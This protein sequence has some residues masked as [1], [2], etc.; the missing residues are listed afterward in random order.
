LKFKGFFKDRWL[1]NKLF[2][3]FNMSSFVKKND[4]QWPPFYTRKDYQL[5]AEL[6]YQMKLKSMKLYHGSEFYFVLL[7][8]FGNTYGPEVAAEVAKKDV[9][10][11]DYSSLDMNR[12][13]HGKHFFP[14]DGHPTPISDYIFAYLLNRDLPTAKTMAEKD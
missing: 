10:V 1:I 6:V 13:T 9:H 14:L 3:Y 11:L 2:T 7:P 5:F 8:G 12:I 4:L